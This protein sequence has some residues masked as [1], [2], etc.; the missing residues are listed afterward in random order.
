MLDK[1]DNVKLV[2]FGVSSM[3]L[4][5]QDMVK[6]SAGSP[7]FM[8]PELISTGGST[9]LADYGVSGR[10]CD[11]WSLGV[12]LYCLAFGNLPFRGESIVEVYDAIRQ[13]PVQYPD[14][15]D[16]DLKLLLEHMLDKSPATRATIPVIRE[17]VWIT[18]HGHQP[19]PTLEENCSAAV[20][21]ITEEDIHKAVKK[22]VNSVFTVLKAASKFKAARRRAKSTAS[23]DDVPPL[24]EAV[25]QA[26]HAT[27]ELG[28]TAATA[29]TAKA[30]KLIHRQCSPESSV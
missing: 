25:S 1:D 2:D 3:F 18:D 29:V 8:A 28:K 19:L 23:T 7:A 16:P 10:A 17:S 26:V 27:S 6:T 24:A 15:C 30:E 21:E 12:V 9:P 13:N 14:S 11:I 5:G 20:T 22:V 4:P